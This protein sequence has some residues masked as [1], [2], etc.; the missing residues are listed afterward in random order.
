MIWLDPKFTIPKDP[1]EAIAYI[2]ELRIPAINRT[3]EQMKDSEF[4]FLMKDLE[5]LD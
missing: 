3:I 1:K 5:M 2:K 4:Y